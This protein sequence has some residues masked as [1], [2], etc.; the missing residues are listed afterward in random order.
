M[1]M[2]EVS[3][4]INQEFV[5][6]YRAVFADGAL[7]RKMKELIALAVSLTTGCAH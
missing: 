5:G 6:F 4:E 3:P 7:D 1:T 2:L